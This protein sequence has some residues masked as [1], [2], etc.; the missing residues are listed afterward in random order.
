MLFNQVS[1]TFI[2]LLLQNAKAGFT[3]YYLQLH[4]PQQSMLSFLV[5]LKHFCG[6]MKQGFL[7]LHRKRM[8]A[9]SRELYNYIFQLYS[10]VCGKFL[11][12]HNLF[13]FFFNSLPGSLSQF[14]CWIVHPGLVRDAHSHARLGAVHFY[15][16]LCMLEGNVS[17]QIPFCN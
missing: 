4:Q 12:S 5:N 13:L 8:W 11:L 9:S 14:S 1:W 6:K 7:E 16:L 17:F 2:D 3:I 10:I 15:T